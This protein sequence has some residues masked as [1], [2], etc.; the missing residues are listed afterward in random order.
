MADF[1][2]EVLADSEHAAE[3]KAQA[4]RKPWWQ[5]AKTVRQGLVMSGGYFAVAVGALIVSMTGPGSPVVPRMFAV[6]WLVFSIWCLVSTLV[7]RRRQQEG[8][9]V[10]AP[11]EGSPGMPGPMD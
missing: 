7:I 6:L 1:F 3:R 2:E 5:L 9:E 11:S 10:D 4:T 8:R